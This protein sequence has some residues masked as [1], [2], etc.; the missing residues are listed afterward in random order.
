MGVDADDFVSLRLRLGSLRAVEP[1][2]PLT[3]CAGTGPAA[4]A[5]RRNL[6]R[7][8]QLEQVDL[9]PP[10]EP[11]VGLKELVECRSHHPGGEPLSV[12]PGECTHLRFCRGSLRTPDPGVQPALRA[13]ASTA[14]GAVRQNLVRLQ[15][16]KRVGPRPVDERVVGPNEPVIHQLLNPER[17]LA[18]L[19]KSLHLCGA[20]LARASQGNL[21]VVSHLILSRSLACR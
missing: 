20:V 9:R 6:V 12:Q 13:D 8:Q 18:L 4:G 15:Q 14:A 11:A 19:K 17:F 5:L 21:L 2:D 10:G 1:G 16:M 7:L 3:L